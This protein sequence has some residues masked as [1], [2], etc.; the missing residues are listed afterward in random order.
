MNE[1]ERMA[2]RY[3]A[4]KLDA[5]RSRDPLY[6]HAERAALIA[7]MDRLFGPDKRDAAILTVLLPWRGRACA[8]Q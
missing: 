2:Q 8:G 5:L 3:V 1:L 4:L 7:E 6:G